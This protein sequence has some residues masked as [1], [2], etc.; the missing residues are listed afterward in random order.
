MLLLLLFLF[1]P[2]Y[3]LYFF[4]SSSLIWTIGLIQINDR[5]ID[6]TAQF[7]IQPSEIEQR[8]ARISLHKSPGPDGLPNWFLCDFASIIVRAAELAE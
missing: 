3:Y 8:L 5:L 1:L 6:Y 4:F 2:F 7:T